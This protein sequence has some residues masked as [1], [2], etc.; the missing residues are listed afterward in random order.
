MKEDINLEDI[1]LQDEVFNYYDDH[2]EEVHSKSNDNLYQFFHYVPKKQHS[3][4][5]SRVFVVFIS[6]AVFTERR[7][8]SFS[9]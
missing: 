5:I 6:R 7:S 1:N 8:P 3:T 9:N 2:P 4:L